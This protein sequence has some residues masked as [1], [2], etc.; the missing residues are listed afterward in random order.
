[1][2]LWVAAIIGGLVQA[3][4]TLV[5]RVLIS[6]GFGYTVFTGI[7]TSITWAR[8]QFVTAVSGLGPTVVSL[9]GTLKIGTAVSII[10]SALAARMLLNGL[11]GGAIRKLT[12]KN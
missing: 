5:G 2:P 3:A 4:G 6:L 12:L 8:D 1:M 9:A 10:S 11:T 7:D